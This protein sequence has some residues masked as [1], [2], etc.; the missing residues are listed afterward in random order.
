[1]ISS[2]EVVFLTQEKIK[3]DKP[4]Y[5][6]F[7]SAI[8]CIKFTWNVRKSLLF[9]ILAQI[10]LSVTI[11]LVDVIL[12]K[13]VVSLI[14]DKSTMSTLVFTVL[15]LTTITVICQ[16]I[17]EYFIKTSESRR[18]QIRFKIHRDVLEKYIYTDYPLLENED[19]NNA[20]QAAIHSRYNDA[21][22]GIYGCYE[23]IG[24]SV[25]GFI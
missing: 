15:S 20:K 4:K 8:Y 13:T 3:K 24:T 7:Q 6:I 9:I 22:G 16:W 1:M 12:P 18:S 25:L 21:Q 23:R 11:S 19:F 2:S 10:F 5:N 14:M 17:K